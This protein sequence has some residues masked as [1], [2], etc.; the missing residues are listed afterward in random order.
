MPL[1]KP[2]RQLIIEA[3]K[4]RILAITAGEDYWNTFTSARVF[5]WKDT[6]VQDH[7]IPCVVIRDGAEP[8]EG[9]STGGAGGGTVD[10][11]ISIE[12]FAYVKSSEA[13]ATAEDVAELARKLLADLIKCISTDQS[14]GVTNTY[15]QV[16]DKD[17]AVEP[18]NKK[19]AFAY[20][21]LEV[22]VPHNR[23]DYA[24]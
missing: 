13:N 24:N 14:W 17:L 19:V 16:V 1:T 2:K 21:K 9:R 18:G 6:P 23:F 10:G 20:L 11:R 15:T 8:T 7:E 5:I 3:M 22:R 4:A 12:W